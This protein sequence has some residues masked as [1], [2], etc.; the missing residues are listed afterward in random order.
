VAEVSFQVAGELGR[1][2]GR[3]QCDGLHG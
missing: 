2:A 1:I 3:P